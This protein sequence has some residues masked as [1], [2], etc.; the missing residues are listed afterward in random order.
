MTKVFKLW[1]ECY[2]ITEHPVVYRSLEDAKESIEDWVDF[3]GMS[4]E[5]ALESEEVV[6]QEWNLV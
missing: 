1:G 3:L 5:E 2:E 4:V 6:I